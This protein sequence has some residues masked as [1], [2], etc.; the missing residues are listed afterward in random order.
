MLCCLFL[1]SFWRFRNRSQSRRLRNL[2]KAGPCLLSA[3]VSS[4][5]QW[6]HLGYLRLSPASSSYRVSPAGI[7]ILGF[8]MSSCSQFSHS[9]LD[10]KSGLFFFP[11]QPTVGP[12]ISIAGPQPR[13][14]FEWPF[15]ASAP[16]KAVFLIRHP[17]FSS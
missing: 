6:D 10:L 2:P 15:S 5:P 3:S 8:S 13:P 4:S 12:N 9:A 11:H 16:S 17:L 7:N 1:P 14:C